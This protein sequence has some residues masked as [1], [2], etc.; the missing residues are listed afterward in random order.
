MG[1]MAGNQKHL[2]A[3]IDPAIKDLVDNL[4]I[5]Y[6]VDE[7][8]RLHR[9]IATGEQQINTAT[10]SPVPSYSELDSTP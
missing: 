2:D 4:L 9:P 8:L 10:S 6:L 5:P 7:F 1:R 3:A